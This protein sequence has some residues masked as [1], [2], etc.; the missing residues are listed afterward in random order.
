MSSAIETQRPL[1]EATTQRFRIASSST[2]SNAWK[3]SL[4]AGAVGVIGSV[5]GAFLDPERF[6]FSYLFA[7][8]V[9]LTLALGSLFFVMIQHLTVANWS[10]V[11]RR[12]AEF[13]LAGMPTIVFLSIPLL[14]NVDHLYEWAHT[15]H[16]EHA[17]MLEM[18]EQSDVIDVTKEGADDAHAAGGSSH[19]EAEEAL[20]H[21]LME[22]KAV[23]LNKPFFYVRAAVY[24]IVWVLLASLYVRWS[25]SQDATG[26]PRLTK[27]MRSRSPLGLALFGLTLT[28]A[29][30]DWLMSLEPAWYST[31]FGVVL[32]AGAAMAIHALLI[33]LALGLKAT[34]D[35]DHSVNKEHFHDLGK[36]M[37]G[38]N[39]FWA[40]V[41]VSQYLL[42]YYAGIPE[43]A[44][45][46][47]HRWQDGSWQAVSIVLVVGH[48]ALP[49]V[50]L[51]SRVVK[52][53]LAWLGVGAAWMLVM[54]LVDLYWLVM[55]YASDAVSVHWL[56]VTCLMTT[57]G[58]YFSLVFRKMLGVPLVPVR[59]PRL[60]RSLR[61]HN[62]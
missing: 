40:Y 28:F 20:H 23:Y 50:L 25:T 53:R 2:W 3:V 6:A 52:R 39:C 32:F 14:L 31:I 29:A 12:L 36:M 62:A 4:A 37:F 17:E 49:F 18:V 41:S 60:A 24:L 57:L 48:F 26:D 19:S 8:M 55:P 22:H 59:D 27:K 38:F 16:H 5:V 7:F 1:P 21:R 9:C 43:E 42:I 54:H 47:H 61:F 58:L 46:Y 44:T 34:G 15:E 10:V 13:V 35:L 56:D 33:L 30:F 45:Y 11:V 51:M